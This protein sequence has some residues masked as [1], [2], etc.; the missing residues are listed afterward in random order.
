MVMRGCPVLAPRGAETGTLR[1]YTHTTPS[2]PPLNSSSMSTRRSA[3]D[4][5]DLRHTL[6]TRLIGRMSVL[7]VIALKARR[8][9]LAADSLLYTIQT[10]ANSQ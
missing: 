6:L 3:K 8:R 9:T 7:N 4:G 5:K 2:L 1:D 10:P